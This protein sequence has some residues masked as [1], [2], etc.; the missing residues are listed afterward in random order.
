M[1][2]AQILTRRWNNVLAIGLGLPALIYGV[3]AHSTLGLSDM[4]AFIGLFIVGV[5]Y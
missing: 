1:I 4:E 2:K 3:L 5:L